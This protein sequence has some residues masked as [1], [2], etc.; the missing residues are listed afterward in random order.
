MKNNHRPATLWTLASLTMVSVVLVVPWIMW[1]S[2]AP[3][4]LNIMI[5]DKSRPDLSYQGHK[6]LVWLLNQQKIVQHTGEHYSY[7]ED[8]YGFDILEGVPRVK[9]LLPDEVTDTDLIYLTANRSSLSEIKDERRQD[10]I[11]EGI[12]TY[13]VQKIR[14]A[15]YKG[16]TIVAE[17]SALANTASPMTR[18]QLYPILGVN[19]SGWQGKSVSDLQSLK[20][21]PRWIR[22]NYEQREKKAWSYHGAGILLVQVDGQVM[23]LEKGTDVKT[24]NVQLEFTQQGRDWS[25]ISQDIYYNGWFDI[26][27]PEP[28]SSTTLAWCKTDLTETGQQK[29]VNAGIPSEFAALV[30]YDDDNQSYYMAGSFGEMKQYSFWRRI[31]GWDIVRAKLTPNQKDIPDMFYWKVY[32]PVMKHILQE[33]QEGR[34]QWP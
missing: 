10:G 19:S 11:Y 34:Q 24:E 23:V 9:R 26:I 13:D 30:R 29:L 20:E 25:G 7:E 14:E 3:V 15:A 6:G 5:I 2:Q 16:V 28:K 4:P 27:V 8:Y 1:Q 31:Q 21:V 18:E 12:T 22:A 32:V 33:V 17:Y